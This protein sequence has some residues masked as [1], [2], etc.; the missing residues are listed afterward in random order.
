MNY[1]VS[2]LTH[3]HSNCA[4]TVMRSVH[5][6]RNL[7]IVPNHQLEPNIQKVK[8]NNNIWLLPLIMV[9]PVHFWNQCTD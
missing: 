8:K 4:K 6:Y 5:T 9:T 1:N 3:W 7:H 2:C